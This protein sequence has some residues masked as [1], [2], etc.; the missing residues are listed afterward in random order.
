MSITFPANGSNPVLALALPVFTPAVDLLLTNNDSGDS[1]TLNLPGSWDGDD[2]TLDFAAGTI[3]DQTGADRTSLLDGLD[4]SLWT[5]EP[6]AP[7]VNSVSAKAIVYGADP[8]P[9]SSGPRSG[10]TFADDSTVGSVAWTNPGN[11]AASDNARAS[12]TFADAITHYLKATNF[13]FSIPSSTVKGIKVEIERSFTSLAPSDYSVKIV[14]GGVISG[15]ERALAGGWPAADTY[16]TYGGSTDLWG[17][18]WASSD[19]NASTFGV[20][21][22]AQGLG[23]PTFQRNALVDHIRVTV[24]YDEPAVPLAPQAYGATGSWSW[25]LAYD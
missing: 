12:A 16:A 5:P 13:G 17:L 23:L 15:S 3:R 2:L 21:V 4:R 25:R 20:V 19:I 22:A 7:G 6:L 1:L 18:N 10:G 9:T 14:K 24:Y 8:P 11:A